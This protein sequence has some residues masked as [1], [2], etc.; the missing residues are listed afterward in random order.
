MELDAA[1][2]KMRFIMT[3]PDIASNVAI[4]TTAE[5]AAEFQQAM[6]SNLSFSGLTGAGEDFSSM[7]VGQLAQKLDEMTRLVT[8]LGAQIQSIQ[9][10][11]AADVPAG[12]YDFGSD[13]VSTAELQ[14]LAL[15]LTRMEVARLI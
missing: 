14:N 9:Q 12:E 7:T 5:T 3:R 8:S 4:A 13:D 1:K 10:A 2:P 11:E 15:M 6:P